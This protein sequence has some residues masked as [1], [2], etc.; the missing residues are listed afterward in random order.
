MTSHFIFVDAV[1]IHDANMLNKKKKKVLNRKEKL[2][3]NYCY[4]TWRSLNLSLKSRAYP[5]TNLSG[6]SNPQSMNFKIVKEKLV[7]IE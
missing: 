1:I 6:I 4:F 3:I 5:T 2:K 7:E